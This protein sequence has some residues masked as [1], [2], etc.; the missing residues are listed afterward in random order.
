MPVSEEAEVIASKAS[1]ILD[2]PPSCIQLS[3]NHPEYVVIGTYNLEKDQSQASEGQE[4]GSKEVQSRNGSLVVFRAED[5][6]LAHVQT[7]ASASALLDLRFH[8]SADF[9][10]LLAVVSSTATLSVFR[11]D[12]E[13]DSS[14][15]LKHIAT[16]R[17]DGVEEDVLFLQFQWHPVHPYVIGVTTS[18]G[19]VMLLQLNE[20]W[21]IA[22]ST[23][24]DI[25]NSLEAWCVAFSPQ[26]I[27]GTGGEDTATSVVYAGG[28]DSKLRYNSY[29]GIVSLA[30]EA[31]YAP[32]TVSGKHDAGVTAI[33]PLDLH[34]P[35]GG[36]LVLT[37]S[38]DDTLRLFA[39]H[40]LDKSYGM[41]RVKPLMEQNLGGGVWR[42]DLVEAKSLDGGAAKIIVLASC[43]YAGARLVEVGSTD[44]QEWSC[45]ILARFEEHKSM[46][47]GCT[48]R[49]DR[50]GASR[51]LLCLS[52]SFYDKL[53]CLWKVDVE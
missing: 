48:F 36:R 39:I 18:T 34:E 47:Y 2:L 1:V 51:T 45:K 43:M 31:E 17:C 49:W 14:S 27:P 20:G 5:D 28:D 46:N 23:S 7:E 3:P 40:D 38:Y 50:Q 12:P 11:L 10:G 53:F 29:S 33:L 30:A 42:L 24:L 21:E 32:Q 9:A 26:P 4:A 16:S 19:S 22:K 37:G 25:E 41:K 44:G 6:S 52:T 8:P 35:N 15:P 13:S